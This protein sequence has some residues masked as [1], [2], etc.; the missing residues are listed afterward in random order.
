MVVDGHKQQRTRTFPNLV[1]VS[2]KDRARPIKIQTRLNQILGIKNHP[3]IYIQI[4]H[5][6]SSSCIHHKYVPRTPSTHPSPHSLRPLDYSHHHLPFILPLCRSLQRANP[7][8]L[9][10]AL[11]TSSPLLLPRNSIHKRHHPLHARDYTQ[12]FCILHRRS[13]P[14]HWSS[15]RGRGEDMAPIIDAYER[16]RTTA[17]P[18]ESVVLESGG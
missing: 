6:L 15:G 8:H 7:H 11:S 4:H 14:H 12:H 2:A 10:P 13:H 9:H 18:A 17:P 5:T 1:G 16:Q 3:S